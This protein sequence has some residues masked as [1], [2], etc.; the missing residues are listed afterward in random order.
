V[1]EGSG[2]RD[3]LLAAEPHLLVG[4]DGLPIAGFG[5]ARVSL[6]WDE[7]F[8]HALLRVEAE[9]PLAVRA[10]HGSPVYEDECVEAFISL[11][12]ENEPARYQEVVVNPAGS[13]YSAV[14]LNPGENRLTWQV[15]RGDPPPGLRLEVRGE[16]HEEPPHLW[17]RWSCT[18]SLPWVRLSSSGRAP[19]PGEARRANFFRIG[20]GRTTRFEAL[21]PTLRIAPP[22]FHVPSR[23]ALLSFR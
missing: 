3:S 11:S 15:E 12:A 6:A 7:V 23:F 1:A 14:V 18:M 16:P 10:A 19:V 13:V 9:P 8:L 2:A 20:R 21:S 22:D 5:G 17:Q 4:L